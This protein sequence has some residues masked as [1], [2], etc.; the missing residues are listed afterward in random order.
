MASYAF[1]GKGSLYVESN[2]GGLFPVGNCSKLS[3]NFSDD[4]KELIDYENAGGGVADVVSFVKS[5]MMT[6]SIFQW[7]PSNI[8]L[9]IRGTSSVYVGG[10]VTAEAHTVNALGEMIPFK[11]IPDLTK[12][13]TVKKGATTFVKGTDY[14]LI[15]A[16][17]VTL[18]GGTLAA[19]DAITIDY[20]GLADNVVQALITSS[21][22]YR[23]FFDGLNDAQ[24]GR[25]VQVEAFN[26]R[27]TP[28]KNLELI[29][30][31]FAD[32]QLEAEILKDSTKIGT[33]LSQ[34]FTVKLANG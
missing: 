3:I 8:A 33:G 12:T 21:D 17:I 14:N 13:I 1:I 30:D 5:V 32:I 26:L 25:P 11:H 16:G 2:G 6:M 15:R 19:A 7:T 18:A 28:P 20:T 4:K 9:A 34:Y 23:V 31:S 10:A 29:G 24:S 22:S 27:F